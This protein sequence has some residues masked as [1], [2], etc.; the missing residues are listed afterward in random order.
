MYD[1]IAVH[2]HDK[3]RIE[4]WIDAVVP[5]FVA[6]TVN[7]EA[8]YWSSHQP[9]GLAKWLNEGGARKRDANGTTGVTRQMVNGKIVDMQGNPVDE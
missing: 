4:A 6:A 5:A 8:K 3:T 1:V 2:C 7:D 9:R